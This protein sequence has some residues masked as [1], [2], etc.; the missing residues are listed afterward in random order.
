MTRLGIFMILLPALAGCAGEPDGW[1]RAM[2]YSW[3]VATVT[4]NG[5]E[6]RVLEH[7]NNGPAGGRIMTTPSIGKALEIGVVEG[8]THGAKSAA[9]SIEAHRAAA[10]ARL[11]A[12]GRKACLIEGGH[13]LIKVQFEFVFTCPTAGKS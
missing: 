8:S 4:V 6:Y 13:E 12:T 7:P 1:S 3:D 10:R 11:D 2:E 9:P 5:A